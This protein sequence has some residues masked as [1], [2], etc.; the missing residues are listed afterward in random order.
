MKVLLQKDVKDVGK[1]GD[2]VTVKKGFARNF[3]FPRNLASEA[4]D[5][6]V[7]EFEHLK[8][9]IEIKKKK[10]QGA[11]KE[12]ISKLEGV[13]VKFNKP[14]GDTDKLFGSVTNVD[15]S[16]ELEK[17][18]FSVDRRDILLEEP[19][20]ILGQHKAQVKLGEGLEAEL[21]ITV[22]RAE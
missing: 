19:I 2:L 6:R 7:K 17:L 9:L 11:R 20:K 10:A 14:A 22:D 8:K 18:G 5:R 4:T 16:D 12:L 1:V 3:L 15:I 13:V 21:T